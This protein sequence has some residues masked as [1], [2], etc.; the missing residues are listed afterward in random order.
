M[1]GT[2]GAKAGTKIAS[3]I[4][5][6]QCTT[7]KHHA[8]TRVRAQ[9]RRGSGA[10]VSR[11][12]STSPVRSPVWAPPDPSDF[13]SSGLTRKTQ[14]ESRFQSLR[15]STRKGKTEKFRTDKVRRERSENQGSGLK[16]SCAAPLSFR[17][18][19][20]LDLKGSWHSRVQWLDSI[21][22]CN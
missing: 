2:S 9:R 20:P 16:M 7:V 14:S 11:R 10:P 13:G 4:R 15:P 21:I 18:P 17:T 12:G 1:R 8:T 22:R 6:V 5:E 3:C 19:R